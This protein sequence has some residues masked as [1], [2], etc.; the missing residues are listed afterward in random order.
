MTP[1]EFCKESFETYGKLWLPNEIV[2]LMRYKFIYNLFFRVLKTIS[3]YFIN[4]FRSCKCISM[5]LLKKSIK[6]LRN[7]WHL[8]MN[9]R[10]LFMYWISLPSELFLTFIYQVLCY[11][12]RLLEYLNT[13]HN[14]QG[15]EWHCFFDSENKTKI[16][17]MKPFW[18]VHS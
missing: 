10:K 11:D 15:A 1:L 13:I 9:S 4:I 14:I 6:L 5:K 2:N 16:R 3:I 7:S 17:I 18:K 12:K 8:P